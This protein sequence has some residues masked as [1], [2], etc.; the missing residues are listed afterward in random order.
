MEE[1]PAAAAKCPTCSSLLKLGAK[2][3]GKC[4][5][6]V[7]SA[8]P[9]AAQPAAVPIRVVAKAN[10]KLLKD[11]KIIWALEPQVIA[12][13]LSEDRMAA[14]S[15]AKGIII[16]EGTRALIFADGKLLGEFTEGE[17]DFRDAL[18]GGAATAAALA[19][20]AATA[21][22]QAS[23]VRVGGVMG[24]LRGLAEWT[25]RMLLGEKV[26]E[27]EAR[28]RKEQRELEKAAGLTALADQPEYSGLVDSF[29]SAVQGKKAIAVV[30]ARSDDFHVVFKYAQQAAADLR[31]D[32]GVDLL[33]RVKDLTDFY[34]DFLMDT[35]VLTT[36]NLSERLGPKLELE[37]AEAIRV[38][39]VEEIANNRALNYAIES[40]FNQ[41]LV[42]TLPSVR[43]SRVF[44]LT[45][46]REEIAELE[47][48]RERLTLSERELNLLQGQ[49]EFANRL[50]VE[51]TRQQ[52][53]ET[54]SDVEL[55]KK[56]REVNKDKI[57]GDQDFDKWMERLKL[58]RDLSSAKTADEREQVLQEL[59]KRELVREEDLEVLHGQSDLRRGH[60]MEMFEL[61]QQLEAD[62]LRLE[63]DQDLG[64]KQLD[65]ELARRRKNLLADLDFLGLEG[66]AEQ[67][68]AEQGLARQKLTDDYQD[69]RRDRDREQRLKDI[70]ADQQ[71]QFRQLDV[72]QRAQTL[73]QS[74]RQQEHERE[75]AQLREVKR[76][77]KELL[78]AEAQRWAGM[79]VEQIMAANPNISVEA[80][81][82]LAERSSSAKAE[83]F[84]RL[85]TQSAQQSKEE[86][87]DMMRQQMET[88]ERMMRSMM[89]SNAAIA[90]AQLRGKEAEIDRAA[91]S[92]DRAEERMTRV[93]SGTVGAV[94]GKTPAGGGAP[95]KFCT[96]CGQSVES[97]AAFCPKCGGK[98]G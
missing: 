5:A 44:K 86:F 77:E 23:V 34:R 53:L 47:R 55:E 36:Q 25:G 64:E 24:A 95:K 17:Y 14:L 27:E 76:A 96:S 43:V 69:T 87:K 84:A 37:V 8:T 88:Q 79:T 41:E 46:H 82:A 93:V 66:Q 49:N 3:C 83:E 40:R 48:K 58:D 80:A 22:G 38:L 32:V 31:T 56:L 92:A 74:A 81:K 33:M 28:R 2:F 54:T 29:L 72:A 75:M 9:P 30:L 18:A 15:G 94:A 62:R 4:G 60:L 35:F 26:S 70:D 45:A 42:R 7:N 59:R 12:Q 39:K 61:R 90:G 1:P 21:A 68:R 63:I 57:L 89:E 67:L 73:A 50:R 19:G 78:E 16:R 52:L 71:E 6:A 20:G 13:R 11:S 85:Q 98:Q 51:E 65:L 97:D 91:S 10:P